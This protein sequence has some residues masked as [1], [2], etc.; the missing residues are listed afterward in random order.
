MIRYCSDVKDAVD[1]EVWEGCCN[2]C[3]EDEDEGYDTM[4]DMEHGGHEYHICCGASRSLERK[5]EEEQYTSIVVDGEKV[6]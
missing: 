6:R 1:D 5:V 3:H 2:S 4:M